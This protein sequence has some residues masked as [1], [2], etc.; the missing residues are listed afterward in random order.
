VTRF[1][2]VLVLGALALA[3]T[4][5]HAQD[6]TPEPSPTP[7][8]VQVGDTSYQM[9]YLYNSP[10]TGDRIQAYPEGTPLVL[11]GGDVEGDGLTWHNVRAPDGTEGYIPTNETTPLQTSGEGSNPT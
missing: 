10:T 8:V 4:T 3:A 11:I 2:R 1:G 6:A 7:E 5:A 9:I